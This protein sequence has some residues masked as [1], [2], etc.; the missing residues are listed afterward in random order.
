MGFSLESNPVHP[1]KTVDD[2]A[3][4]L[5]DQ[6]SGS[7]AAVCFRA[8]TREELEKYR[9]MGARMVLVPMTVNVA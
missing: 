2:C 4:H 8:Y 1:L 6:L 5:L 3:R 9:D 7:A